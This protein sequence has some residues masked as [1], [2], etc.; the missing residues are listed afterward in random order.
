ME[1]YQKG[2]FQASDF[3]RYGVE[4][5]GVDYIQNQKA[6][7]TGSAKNNQNS[8]RNNKLINRRLKSGNTNNRVNLSAYT[9]SQNFVDPFAKP[10]KKNEK[11]S[12]A[13]SIKDKQK[14]STSYHDKRL[15]NLNEQG[16][17]NSIKDSLVASIKQTIADEEAKGDSNQ[18]NLF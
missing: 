8:I 5:K 7:Q 14:P 4:H 3:Q 13:K 2:S 15:S 18:V 9:N 6:F 17:G 12:R 16:S 1:S 11:G 10:K